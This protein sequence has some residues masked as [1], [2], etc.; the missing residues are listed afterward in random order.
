MEDI[1]PTEE[2]KK[3]MSDIFSLA[4]SC[5]FLIVSYSFFNNLENKFYLILYVILVIYYIFINGLYLISSLFSDKKDPETRKICYDWGVI[6]ST[7][8]TTLCLSHIILCLALTIPLYSEANIIYYF[9][10]LFIFLIIFFSFV[11]GKI[12]VSRNEAP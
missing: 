9:I 11:L 8:T 5:I 4:L 6:E 1:I 7:L 3:K 12:L 2:Q 10:S